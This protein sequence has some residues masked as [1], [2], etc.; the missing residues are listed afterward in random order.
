MPLEKSS[1]PKQNQRMVQPPLHAP[2]TCLYL[3]QSSN[4][5][6]QLNID[7]PGNPLPT[8]TT[9]RI[10]KIHSYILPPPPPSNPTLGSNTQQTLSETMESKDNAAQ[11]KTPPPPKKPSNSSSNC[12]Y[13]HFFC[14]RNNKNKSQMIPAANKHKKNQIIPKRSR[15]DNSPKEFAP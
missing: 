2:L 4:N 6:L 13:S 11:Q 9:T 1:P 12:L 10:K 8:I 3:L 7:N 15:V 14:C 5:F